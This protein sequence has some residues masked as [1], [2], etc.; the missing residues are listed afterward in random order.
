MERFYG[1]DAV[2]TPFGPSAVTI[3]KFDGVH[4]GHRAVLERL[5]RVADERGLL[6]VVVTFDRHPLALLAPEKC[7]EALVSL[8]QKL[9]LLA[10]TGVA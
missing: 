6:P 1:L 10:E 8:E 5:H 2:P 4:V 7:P 9:E 3:G